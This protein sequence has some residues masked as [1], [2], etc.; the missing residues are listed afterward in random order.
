M[1]F[2]SL[3]REYTQKKPLD[4]PQ[5]G[6]G[7]NPQ[8]TQEELWKGGETESHTYTSAVLF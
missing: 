4:P 8:Q 5:A 7:W 2:S 1:P 6:L 3:P